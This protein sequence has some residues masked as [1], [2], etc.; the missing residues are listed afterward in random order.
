MYQVN[1]QPTGSLDATDFANSPLAAEKDLDF[2]FD[3]QS[4]VKDFASDHVAEPHNPLHES[5]LDKADLSF[6]SAKTE[7]HSHVAEVATVGAL[8]AAGMAAESILGGHKDEAHTIEALKDDNALDF[9]MDSFGKDELPTITEPIQ[10][11]TEEFGYTMLSD[12]MPS[13]DVPTFAAP[14]F[15]PEIIHESSS[16]DELAAKTDELT[17][18]FEF[19]LTE[20]P[21]TETGLDMGSMDAHYADAK[22]SGETDFNF[23]I[24][25]LS[26]EAKSFKNTDFSDANT[27]D[28]TT[29]NLDLNEGVTDKVADTLNS[30]PA[31]EPIE[32]ETKL[33]L[34]AAYIEMDDKEGAK[35]LL[36]EVMKEGGA[37]QRKRAEALLEKLV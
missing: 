20:A 14:H 5:P 32:I 9:D 15:M 25:T 23:D 16:L 28:L 29:I 6:A 2:S 35:E 26:P 21:Q 1:S 7:T 13:L 24:P 4:L 3:N 36:D 17:E 19:P 22:V 10:T 11:V 31:A 37:N 30:I 33:D 12:S 8:A 18:S 34:V 27:F